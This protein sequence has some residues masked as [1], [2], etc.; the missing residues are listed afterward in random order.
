MEPHVFAAV[1]FAGALHAGWNAIIKVKLEPLLAITLISAAAFVIVLPAAPFVPYPV[2]E[3]WPYIIASLLIHG[4]YYYGLAEAYRAG[5]LSH[6]YPIARGSAPLVTAIGAY[7]IVGEDPGPRGTIGILVLAS[8]ILLLALRGGRADAAFN[9]RAVSFAIFTALAIAAY[10]LVDGIGA[11]LGP[12]AYGYI[13]WLLLTDGLMMLVFGV[14]WFGRAGFQHSAQTWAL[15]GA[16]GFM[17][18]V[19]YAI[20]IWAMSQAPIALVAALR[21]TSVMFAALI[22]IVFL[23]EPIVPVRVVAAAIVVCGIVLVRLR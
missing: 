18:M 4:I 2:P 17:S 13:Y 16:A 6:M 1:L 5:D 19:A 8:G 23:R 14:L 7:L 22:G 12:N 9:G 11:R 21:E 15:L 10:T 3:A 20:A